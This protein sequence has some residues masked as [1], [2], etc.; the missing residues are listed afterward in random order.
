M[1]C[2]QPSAPAD[3]GPRFWPK[4]LSISLIAARIE[5][6]AGPRSYAWAAAW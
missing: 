3:E 2:I 6:P 4:P 5:G 1:N